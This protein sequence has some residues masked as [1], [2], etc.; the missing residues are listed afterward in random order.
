MRRIGER[1]FNNRYVKWMRLE[2]CFQACFDISI[3]FEEYK[4]KFDA[5]N[6]AETTWGQTAH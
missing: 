5:Q 2:K 3:L 1:D 4:R 6:I